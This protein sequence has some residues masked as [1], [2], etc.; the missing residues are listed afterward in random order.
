M[1]YKKILAISSPGGHWIQLN[2]L[3][4]A[5]KDHELIMVKSSTSP[6]KDS[7]YFI[8]EASRWN[9]LLLVKQAIQVLRCLIS[10]KPQLIITTGAS[11]GLWAILFGRLLGAKCIWIES[12]ANSEKLSLSGRLIK[13]FSNIHLTQWPELAKGKTQYKGSVL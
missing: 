11:V 13:P 8:T 4:P 2:R 9:K 12:L 5:F 7:K 6:N 3:K 1:N 10:I